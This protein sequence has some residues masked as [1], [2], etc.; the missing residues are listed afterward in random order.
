[1]LV[2]GNVERFCPLLH[3]LSEVQEL[4]RVFLIHVGTCDEKIGGRAI[5]G[6]RN[7]VH[8]RNAKQ[9]LDVGIMRLGGERVGKE[10]DDIDLSV[11]DPRADLLIASERTAVIFKKEYFSVRVRLVLL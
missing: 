3:V 1:M 9:S 8:L 4:A 2:L 7:I 11:D 6:D 5:V 10:D